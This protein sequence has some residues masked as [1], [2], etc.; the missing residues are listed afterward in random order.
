M[1]KM[2]ILIKIN[3]TLLIDFLNIKVAL[4]SM[5]GIKTVSAGQSVIMDDGLFRFGLYE[6]MIMNKVI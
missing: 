6:E 2:N 1:V 5:G 3:L 4:L